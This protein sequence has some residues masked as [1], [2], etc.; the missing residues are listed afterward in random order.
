M[1]IRIIKEKPSTPRGILDMPVREA[2]KLIK[3]GNAVAVEGDELA[4]LGVK[5]ISRPPADK[6]MKADKVRVK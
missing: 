3:S 5:S 2:M 6:M 4:G 1:I